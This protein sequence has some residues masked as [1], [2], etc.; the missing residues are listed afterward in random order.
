MSRK[1]RVFDIDMPEEAIGD[2]KETFPAGKSEQGEKRRG[3]MASAIAESASSSRE[4]TE[5]ADQIRQENDALAH[6]FMRLKRLG[7]VVEV[8]EVDA[9]KSDKLVRDRQAEDEDAL[10]ELIASIR[11]VGL[12]N[13]V[14]L[15]RATDDRFELVQGY[16]RL[17]AYR[18]LLAETGDAETY[19]RIPAIVLPDGQTLDALYRKMVDENMVRKDISFAEMAQ[20]AINYSM[21]ARTDEISADKAVALLFKS[22]GYQKRSYIRNFIKVLE[23]IGSSLQYP[24]ELPR[25]LGVALAS[26]IVADSQLAEKITAKLAGVGNR[27]SEVELEILRGFAGMGGTEGAVGS[28]KSPKAKAVSPAKSKTSFQFNRP[29]GKAKC[30]AGQGVLEVRVDR[31]FSMLE[32]RKLEQAINSLLDSLGS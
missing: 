30:I 15:E 32:R 19:G 27:T 21:D 20:L 29:E 24:A 25:A 1:R 22:A 7:L 9:I 5:V 14:Q 12:S 26:R 4:R 23:H 13:P 2:A 8:V 3:P 11:D 31:D 28:V 6:E 10:V 17:E 18:R 16:R